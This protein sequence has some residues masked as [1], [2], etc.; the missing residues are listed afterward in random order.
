M[1]TLRN[2]FM[3]CVAAALACTLLAAAQGR[4]QSPTSALA[5]GLKAP[6]KVIV[7]DRD[8]LL[9]AEDGDGRTWAASPS[10]T[11]RPARAGR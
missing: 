9:V 10:S 5:G 4:A 1:K 6:N 3:T 7:A 2:Q 8:Y 11:A